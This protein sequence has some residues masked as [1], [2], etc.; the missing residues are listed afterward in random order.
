MLRVLYQSQMADQPIPGAPMTPPPGALPPAP[1][2]PKNP[3]GGPGGP[4]GS[5]MASGGDGAGNEAAADTLVKAVI[6]ALVKALGAYPVASKKWKNVNRA[7]TSLVAEFGKSN[8]DNMVPA[9]LQQMASASK[10]ASP[11]SSAPPAGIAPAA[12]P[13]GPPP[14]ADASPLAA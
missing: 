13:G 12:G 8:T 11:L 14:G 1:M 4:G 2:M 3:M 7:L 9:A 6:P 10:G 5:P